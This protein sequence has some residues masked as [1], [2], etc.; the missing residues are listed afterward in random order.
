MLPPSSRLRLL[1][2]FQ[3]VYGPGPVEL[4][5]NGQRLLALLGLRGYTPRTVIAGTLW[6]EVT[7]E[8]ARGSLRTTLWKLPRGDQP[9]IQCCG[10]SLTAAS[11]L[12]VDV[13]DFTA[14]ALRVIQDCGPP[15][16][17][18]PALLNGEDLLPGWDE[19]WVLME[20]ERLRQL[21]LQALDALAETLVRRDRPALALEAAWA[22]VRTEPLRESAHRA[23]VAAH[24]ADGNL[25]EAVRH[26]RAFRRRLREELGVEP[27]PR[28]TRMLTDAGIALARAR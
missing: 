17:A 5:R 7:E 19:D 20:R 8:H 24:L 12:R 13:S 16:D 6:P 23:V 9:L 28:F 10:D 4:G 25:C 14:A 11:E 2:R 1:G 15:P 18:P 3:L 21:R 22:S 26:Y 27:S